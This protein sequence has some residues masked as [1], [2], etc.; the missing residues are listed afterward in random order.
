MLKD[1]L[2]GKVVIV[3]IGNVLKG[4]DAFGV[5]LVDRLAGKVPAALINAGVS[6]ENYT[7]KIAKENPDCILLVDAA[8]LGKKPGE[9]EIL[10]RD[11]I[12]KSGFTTHDMSPA[13][14]IDYM[15]ERTGAEMY[16]LGVQPKNISLGDEM[17][18]VVKKA[19]EEISELIEE[20]VKNA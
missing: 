16:L 5:M 4:D 20:E 18:D 17:S 6:P 8:D 9:W 2:K 1:I 3:G 15:K 10:K 11:E 13:M 14:F 12:L 19:L 7:G